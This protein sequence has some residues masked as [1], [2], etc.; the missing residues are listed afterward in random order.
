MAHWGSQR[1]RVIPLQYQIFGTVLNVMSY[2]HRT[3]TAKI[4][5]NL[6]F[7]VFKSKPKPWVI[8]F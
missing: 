4:A 6:W 5:S 1:R 2:V 3:F 7:T 8:K